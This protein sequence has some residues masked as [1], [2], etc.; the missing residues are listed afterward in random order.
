MLT[1]SA[2]CRVAVL[3]GQLPR[4]Q[5]PGQEG[6]GAPAA[7]GARLCAR[8]MSARLV[9][10]AYPQ[11]SG[12]ALETQNFPNSVNTPSFPQCILRPGVEVRPAE[13]GLLASGTAGAGGGLRSVARSTNTSVYGGCTPRSG[14]GEATHCGTH[15]TA[16]QRKEQRGR[17]SEREWKL[18]E[19][20]GKWARQV[21]TRRID[22][23][24]SK[25]WSPFRPSKGS[26][27][28]T[29][30]RPPPRLAAQEISAGTGCGEQWSAS[31]VK[32]GRHRPGAGGHRAA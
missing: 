3:L 18:A 26:G 22:N 19:D 7:C 31:Q 30:L 17:K 8:W 13:L 29:P 27:L 21:K 32:H 28:G 5:R 2:C 9:L 23:A 11:Y 20:C 24:V 12:F 15:G 14:R 25:W 10:Q 1:F 4:R 6:G 16:G